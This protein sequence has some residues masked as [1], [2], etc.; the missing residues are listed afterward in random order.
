MYINRLC[1]YSALLLLSPT[2]INAYT[3]VDINSGILQS[4][5][6]SVSGP[7]ID[8]SPLPPVTSTLPIDTYK[9]LTANSISTGSSDSGFFIGGSGISNEA[10]L[11]GPVIFS[12][13]IPRTFEADSLATASSSNGF[14]R[15]KASGTFIYRVTPDPSPSNP[16]NQQRDGAYS[17]GFARAQIFNYWSFSFDR[18]VAQQLLTNPLDFTLTLDVNS[19][20]APNP[21]TEFDFQSQID[22]YPSILNVDFFIFNTSYNPSTVS[23]TNDGRPAV[24]KISYSYLFDKNTPSQQT[25]TINQSFNKLVELWTEGGGFSFDGDNSVKLRTCLGLAAGPYAN[26]C[27]VGFR[28][29]ITLSTP[30]VADIA[31]VSVNA[32]W[33]ANI[34]GA[35]DD[36]DIVRTDAG[37]WGK[38]LDP[39]LLVRPSEILAVPEPQS[40][41]LFAIGF[42]VLGACRL[43]HQ[44]QVLQYN[45]SF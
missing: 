22:T 27:S 41:A 40:V 23:T 6:A 16:F 38:P 8:G 29:E 28:T 35:K 36:I 1:L 44:R 37:D 17:S 26:V 4:A 20:F 32:T 10:K 12:D 34:A 39:L 21:N 11:A 25:L 43:R 31:D 2:E 24:E 9:Y 42:V 13:Q 5:F 3:L 45:S 19:S 14:M 30:S 33:D 18:D 15:A 7:N